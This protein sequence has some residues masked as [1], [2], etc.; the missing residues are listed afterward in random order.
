[1][2][3]VKSSSPAVVTGIDRPLDADFLDGLADALGVP[4]AGRRSFKEDV[5]RAAR[6]FRAERAAPK[7]GAIRREI[8]S[9]AKSIAKV[10]NKPTQKKRES[11]RGR[12]DRLSPE[13]INFLLR[14]RPP[15]DRNNPPWE[16][17]ALTRE[18]LEDLYA[19]CCVS[20]RIKD[21]SGD[22][23]PKLDIKYGPVKRPGAPQDHAKMTLTIRLGAAFHTAKGAYPERPDIVLM[24]DW[25]LEKLGVPVKQDRD[26]QDTHT[27]REYLRLLKEPHRD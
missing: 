7:V 3:I 2:H 25:V 15:H 22:L 18:E 6:E 13:A 11:L 20:A 1:M 27:A 4:E 14:H 9:L 19:R 21:G 10:L 17:N 24:T 8:T 5:Q 26:W 16:M 23:L 12:L